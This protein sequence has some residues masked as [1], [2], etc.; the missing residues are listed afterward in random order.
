MIALILILTALCLCRADLI[1]D[2]DHVAS[3][4]YTETAAALAF[5]EAWSHGQGGVLPQVSHG[6]M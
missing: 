5:E 3:V 2:H 6:S 1:C 4:H